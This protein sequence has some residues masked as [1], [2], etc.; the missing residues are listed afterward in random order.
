MTQI[1][2]LPD[3]LHMLIL[4]ALPLPALLAARGVCKLWR[5]LVP[6]AHIP[7]ARRGLLALYL[8]AA[9]SPAF[10]ATRKDV[11]ARTHSWNR[12][13]Y[14]SRLPADLPEDFACWVR[15][16]PARAVLGLLWPGARTGRH[17]H[18]A[19]GLLSGAG[20]AILGMTI[21][22]RLAFDGGARAVHAHMFCADVR[23]ASGAALLLDDAFV[24]GRQRSRVLVLDGACD[25]VEMAGRVYAVEGTSCAMDA[26]EA[27]SWTEF[28]HQELDRE[29]RWLASH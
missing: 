23:G 2:D 18:A 29:E 13:A 27:V 12:D 22:N 1:M 26:P 14:L 28:L 11:L 9:A 17:A 19:P 5:A 10:L 4:A 16:W 8:R 6:G 3:E 25:G 24:R 15:E 20:H 21:L 7:A